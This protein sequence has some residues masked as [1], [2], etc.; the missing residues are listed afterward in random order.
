M[1]AL[2]RHL[3]VYGVGSDD[4]VLHGSDGR[5]VARQWFGDTWR[6][7]RNRAELPKAR[8]HDTRH[9]YASTL[10]AGGVSIPAVAEYMGH[11]PAELLRTYADLM[12]GDHDRARSAVQV[13][14]DS[15]T[16]RV[17]SVSS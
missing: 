13:A 11:S 9:T 2:A 16:T 10:L 7:L 14:F 4:L 8:Y 12:P 6:S 15:A 3:E 17:T 1:T 5:P